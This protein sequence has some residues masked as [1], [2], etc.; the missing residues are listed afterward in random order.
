MVFPQPYFFPLDVSEI[1]GLS[2]TSNYFYQA[3]SSTISGGLAPLTSEFEGYF[4]ISGQLSRFTLSAISGTVAAVDAANGLFTVG[5]TEYQVYGASQDGTSLAFGSL[6]TPDANGDGDGSSVP[7]G[8][9]V[10]ILSNSGAPPTTDVVTYNSLDPYTPICFLA[11]T[12][13][14]TMRGE[15]DVC[16]LREG[17]LLPTRF[18]GARAIRWIGRQTFNPCFLKK[19]AGYGG[20]NSMPIRICKDALSDGVPARD[21]L[22][23]PGHSL[24]IGERLILARDLVNDFSIFQDNDIAKVDYYHVDLGKHDCVLAEHAWTESYADHL[25]RH[26]FHNAANYEERFG[27]TAQPEPLVPSA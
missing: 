4:L 20:L 21:L 19:N 23:S 26:M 10:Y 15:V 22:V 27:R 6:L 5:G 1:D 16:E 18:R 11:G 17:D 2:F 8:D 24:L 12:R 13:I 7:T 25:N 14:L 9:T 3:S